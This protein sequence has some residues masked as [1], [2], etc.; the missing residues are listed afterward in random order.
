MRFKRFA[1]LALAVGLALPATARADLVIEGRAAQ[2]LHCATMNLIISGV[3]YDAGYISRR[4]AETLLAASI[5]I[6]DHV[7]GTDD[8]K[9]QAVKQRGERIVATRTLEQLA[10]EFN[11][12]AKFCARTFL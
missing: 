8:Q 10:K 2:A 5:K 6:L 3:L 7:P 12:S 11:Q 1:A 4:D 9:L